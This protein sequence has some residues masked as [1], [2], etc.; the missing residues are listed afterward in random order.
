MLETIMRTK[1]LQ[2]RNH[3]HFLLIDSGDPNKEYKSKSKV[4]NGQK[5]ISRKRQNYY[6]EEIEARLVKNYEIPIIR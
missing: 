3:T 6:R 1:N 5:K 2:T 4:I